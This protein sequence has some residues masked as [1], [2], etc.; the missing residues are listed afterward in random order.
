MDFEKIYDTYFDDVYLYVRRLSGNEHIADEIAS[1]TFFKAMS[2]IKNF[3]GECDIRVWLCQIAKNSYFSYLK[4]NGKTI[5]FD[6]VKLQDLADPNALL[7]RKIPN[8]KEDIRQA[9]K[10]VHT[11]PE[12]YREVFMWRVFADLSFKQIGELFHKTD[13]WACVTYHRARKMIKSRLEEP[14]SEK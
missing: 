3:R 1:E 14:D 12:L 10:A 8:E 11:L 13:N 9:Q 5:G 6:D 2:S 7:P 4:K